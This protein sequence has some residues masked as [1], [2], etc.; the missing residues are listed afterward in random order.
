MNKYIAVIIIIVVLKWKKYQNILINN[1]NNCCKISFN[2]TFNNTCSYKF[3]NSCNL[4]I[5][6]CYIFN[7]IIMV[8]NPK[9]FIGIC[10]SY[11]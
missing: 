11:L 2:L 3:N 7:P 10:N 6:F 4:Y 9:E 8:H 1:C 5:F